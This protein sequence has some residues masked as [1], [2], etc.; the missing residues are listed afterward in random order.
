MEGWSQYSREPNES[1]IIVWPRSGKAA[2]RVVQLVGRTAIN[3]AWEETW[4]IARGSANENMLERLM[5]LGQTIESVVCG[6]SVD[7]RTA[8][9]IWEDLDRI[10]HELNMEPA[11]KPR[12]VR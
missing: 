3:I 2:R 8:K 12:R 11:T 5:I 6:G 10:R 4:R 7:D 9:G 1:R